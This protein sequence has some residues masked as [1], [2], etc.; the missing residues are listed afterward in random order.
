VR[1]QVRGLF[2]GKPTRTAGGAAALRAQPLTSGHPGGI[3]QT[4]GPTATS[5]SL[6]RCNPWFAVGERCSFAL[7]LAIRRQLAPAHEPR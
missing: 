2:D 1:G 4:A 5:A 3:R 7:A 6:I